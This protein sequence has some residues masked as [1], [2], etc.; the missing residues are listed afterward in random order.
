[1]SLTTRIGIIGGNGWLGNAIAD[2]AVATGLIEPSLLTLS[3][4]SDN[5]GPAEIAGA[6]WT[7]DNAELANRSDVI[8]LSVRPEQ[9]PAIQVDAPGK[10]IIS[11]MAAVPAQRITRQTNSDRVIRSMPN[12]A[13]NIRK[14][15]TPWFATSGAS[16]EDRELVR[17][18]FATCG[19]S[20]E[21]LTETH[22]DYCAGLTGSGAAFPALL[23]EAMINH[24]EAQGLSR[25]FAR[26]AVE[27]VV[28]GASQLLTHE[29]EGPGRMIQVLKGY[30]GTTAAAL[31]AMM[32]RG[33]SDAVY[34]GLDAAA[35]KAVAMAEQLGK[36]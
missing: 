3:S 28:A 23:A 12:G 8:V 5:R 31:T 14:S 19:D 6:Y 15:F 30:R 2:A 32:E 26:R 25:A 20:E 11:V 7:K 1:M 21:V 27:G 18:L 29:S 24:A 4:R 36:V 13:V 34:A 16:G 35:H 33:F 22:L 9:F 10:L 17:A